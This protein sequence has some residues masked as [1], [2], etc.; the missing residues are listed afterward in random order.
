MMSPNG[1]AKTET[2]PTNSTDGKVLAST[3]MVLG[4]DSYRVAL[5]PVNPDQAYKFAELMAS[6]GQ[7]GSL[8]EIMGKIALGRTLGLPW[9]VALQKI[10]LIKSTYA[11]AADTLHALC[12]RAKSICEYF[13]PVLAECDAEKA[14][15]VT[16]RVGRPEQRYV[17]TIEDAEL[18]GVVD[19]GKDDKAKAD[20]NWVKVRKQMLLARCKSILARLIYPDL[21][22]G[23]YSFEEL[24]ASGG[25]EPE[26]ITGEVLSAAEAATEAAAGRVISVQVAPRDYAKEAESLKAKIRSAGTSRQAAQE[27]REAIAAWDGVEPHKSAVAAFYN[28]V[29]EERRKAASTATTDAAPGTAEK[30][31]PMPEGNLFGK[32]EPAKGDGK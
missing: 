9:M 26:E 16:K 10:H 25:L 3:A 31:A 15:F 22:Q 30:P 12:L 29:R 11:V 24:T 21:T 18:M 7:W 8:P 2:A 4:S 13:E 28:E 6:G 19:R 20:N 5:E 23:L 27:V 32:T 1:N 14:T 17:Y